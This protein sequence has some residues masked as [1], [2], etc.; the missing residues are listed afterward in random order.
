MLALLLGYALVLNDPESKDAYDR[1]TRI[2]LA[3]GLAGLALLGG[4]SEAWSWCDRIVAW[5]AGDANSYRAPHAVTIAVWVIVA[6]T[7]L[8]G[9]IF[10]APATLRKKTPAHIAALAA[11]GSALV[12]LVVLYFLE[13]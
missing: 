13:P 10:S 3:L 11:C 1:P 8:H 12:G 9:A 4:V 2:K 6:A 5:I 7:M